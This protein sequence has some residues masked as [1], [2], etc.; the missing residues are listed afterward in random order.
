MT[1]RTP[2]VI[3]TWLLLHLGSRHYAQ[4]LAGDLYEE[5]QNDRSRI[6]YWRQVM[7]AIFLAR[8]RAL[9]TAALTLAD[10]VLA[11]FAL[12]ALG[13]GTL[14]WANVIKHPPSTPPQACASSSQPEPTDCAAARRG[15]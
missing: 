12:L 10:A 4:S 11:L 13:A 5:Y 14:A 6:W 15:R 7:F 8:T 2:S 9:R 1:M 3:A